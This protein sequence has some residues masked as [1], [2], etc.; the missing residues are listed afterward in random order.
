MLVVISDLHFT[1][2][3]TGKSFDP[4]NIRMLRNR[5]S[6]MAYDASW[7]T[8]KDGKGKVYNPIK[9][10]DVVLLGDIFDLIRSTAWTDKNQQPYNDVNFPKGS[11]RKSELIFP[12]FDN[13]GEIKPWSDQKSDDFITMVDYVTDR[14]IETNKESFDVFKG[15]TGERG[16]TLPPAINGKVV[17]GVTHDMQGEERVA[18]K[19]RLHYIVGN[20]DWFYYLE[21]ETTSNKEISY[22]SIREKVINVLGLSNTAEPFPHNIWA[23]RNDA[24]SKIIS[25]LCQDHDLFVRHGDRFDK[26]NYNASGRDSA[27][28]GD[29]F[30]VKLFNLF[31]QKVKDIVKGLPVDLYKDMFEFGNVSPTTMAPVW[32]DGVLRKYE[33]SREKTKEVNRVWDQLAEDI[34]NNSFFSK[35]DKGQI[36]LVWIVLRLIKYFGFSHT[37]RIILFFLKLVKKGVSYEKYAVKDAKDHSNFNYFVYGHTHFYEYV[38][39]AIINRDYQKHDQIY[40]NS[41]TWH[42]MHMSTMASPGREDFVRNNV[43]TFL[44]FYNNGERMGR[45]YEVWNA[46]LDA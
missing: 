42:N 19:V 12:D 5:L 44:A 10:L 38:P 16:I 43:L 7:S 31:P 21:N 17:E 15:L 46:I 2:G 45:A 29:L 27:T 40:V 37:S 23:D 35:Q 41:G 18:V 36:F 34:L 32:V 4:S 22:H 26:F 9:A 33:V 39:I 30:V 11:G 14:V 28:L 24:Q 3:T 20:H 1:D 8:G 13:P 25:Q 6:D